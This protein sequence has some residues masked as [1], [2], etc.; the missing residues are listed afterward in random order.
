M[1]QREREWERCQ[2]CRAV[3]VALVTQVSE[4]LADLVFTADDVERL[5]K[6]FGQQMDLANSADQAAR[7]TSDLLMENTHVRH[8]MDGTGDPTFRSSEPQ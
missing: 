3:T 1:C 5:M 4:L 8:L 2:F 7:Q 6:V